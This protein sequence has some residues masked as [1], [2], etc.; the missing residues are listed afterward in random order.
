MAIESGCNCLRTFCWQIEIYTDKA[1]SL[2]ANVNYTIMS[3][4]N[5]SKRRSHN[6][7]IEQGWGWGGVTLNFDCGGNFY[8]FVQWNHNE[9]LIITLCPRIHTY[10]P[11]GRCIWIKPHTGT[12]AFT[13]VIYVLDYWYGVFHAHWRRIIH[14]SD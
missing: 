1:M 5:P 7:F 11:R 6:P 13:A 2:D 3:T 14:F 9:Y 12:R 8:T 4:V 10:D